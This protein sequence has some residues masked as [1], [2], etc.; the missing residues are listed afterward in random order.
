MGLACKSIIDIYVVEALSPQRVRDKDRVSDK[1]VDPPGFSYLMLA[2][3]TSMH[4]GQ[5][6]ANV[7]CI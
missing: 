5:N 7:S 2:R 1:A 3:V 4:S 6:T